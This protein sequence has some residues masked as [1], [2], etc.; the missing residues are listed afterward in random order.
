MADEEQ[1]KERVEGD[2]DPEERSEVAYKR[3][4]RTRRI[5]SERR[6]TRFARAAVIGVVAGLLAV[7]FQYA[8]FGVEELR[9]FV[10]AA[11]SERGLPGWVRLPLIGGVVGLFA[12]RV[13][14]ARLGQHRLVP[15]HRLL[16][17]YCGSHL[18]RA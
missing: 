10:R 8:I 12:L 13:D 15:D 17:C 4:R 7:T 14:P 5:L 6:N 18:C 16:L 3:E 11:F 1:A 2:L 9:L